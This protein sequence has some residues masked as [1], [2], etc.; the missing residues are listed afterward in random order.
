ML[1]ALWT[2]QVLKGHSLLCERALMKGI[3]SVARLD[4][5]SDVI[6]QREIVSKK[7]GIRLKN[8]YTSFLYLRN[9]TLRNN[10]KIFF[11]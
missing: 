6:K 5:D 9:E 4:M 3:L 11:A 1:D 7:I 2:G 10:L 8:I